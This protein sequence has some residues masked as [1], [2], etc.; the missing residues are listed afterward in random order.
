MKRSC[1]NLPIFP[2]IYLAPQNMIIPV[3]HTKIFPL[4]DIIS[5]NRCNGVGLFFLP[6]V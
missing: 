3:D 4:I 5:S 6:S 1:W 2:N